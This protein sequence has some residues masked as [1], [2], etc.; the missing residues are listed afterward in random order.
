MAP[1][2]HWFEFG[3]RK[4]NPA[5][6]A[7]WKAAKPGEPTWDSPWGP[8]RP[9]RLSETGLPAIDCCGQQ[10]PLDFAHEQGGTSSAAR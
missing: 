2:R 8:G 9:G 6:F 3:H 10:A 5:D 4:R 1:E 7:L